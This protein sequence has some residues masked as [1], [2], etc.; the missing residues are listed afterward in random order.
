MLANEPGCEKPSIVTGE[1]MA[2]SAELGVIVWT[3]EPVMLKLIVSAPGFALASRI[4]WRSEPAP[5]SAVVVTV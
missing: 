5:E 1:V 4:A 2:G 3:P